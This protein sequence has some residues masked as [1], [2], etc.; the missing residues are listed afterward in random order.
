MKF[1]QFIVFFY[2]FT[3]LMDE[4]LLFILAWTNF[5][6]H[7]TLFFIWTSP[8]ILYCHVLLMQI[9]DNKQ[10]D[11]CYIY[12]TILFDSFYTFKKAG[13]FIKEKILCKN[14]LYLYTCSTSLLVAP[15]CIDGHETPQL[16]RSWLHWYS[17][18]PHGQEFKT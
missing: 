10:C 18:H 3:H 7:N 13:T 2:G 1:V 17:N 15:S 9:W 5:K 14:E 16:W 6:P 12:F 8:Y 11:Q 4:F